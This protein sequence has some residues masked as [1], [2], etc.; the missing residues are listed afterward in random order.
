VELLYQVR[1]Y[2]FAV[3]A[4]CAAILARAW[5]EPSLGPEQPYITF[6]AAVIA[7]AWYAGT[8]PGL[9]AI[10]LGGLAADY[11]FIAPLYTLG[12]ANRLELFEA[13]TFASVCVFGVVVIEAQR[14][15]QRR[16]ERALK[17]LRQE[18]AERERSEQNRR[19]LAS[20]VESSDDAIVS[21]DLDG[22]MIAWNEGATRMY[23]YTKAEVVGKPIAMLFPSGE[24]SRP[25]IIVERMQRG[26][27]IEHYEAERRRKDGRMISVSVTVSPVRAADG[28]LIGI[29][30][31][32]RDITPRKLAE[33]ELAH[34]TERIRNVLDSVGDGFL[35]VDA[36]GRITYANAE[37]LRMA[38]ARAE[39]FAGAL[40]WNV[41]MVAGGTEDGFRR[42]MAERRTLRYE[43][44]SE[45][46]G[47]WTAVSVFPLQGGLS[48]FI[49]DIT[50][51]KK[52]EEQLRATLQ[53]LDFHVAN[54]PLAVVEWDR[55][56][57]VVRWSDEAA[58]VF[59]RSAAEVLGRRIDELNMIHPDDIA[60]VGALTAD[61]L[62]GRKPRNV[63]INRN[64]R[65]DGSTIYCE[66]YNSVLQDRAGALESVLSLVLDVTDRVHAEQ[67]LRDSEERLELAQRVGGIG[68]YDW[69]VRTGA[70]LW[71]EQTEVLFGLKRGGFEGHFE[72]WAQRV[73]PDD[74]GRVMSAVRDAMGR[75]E[76]Q[77]SVEYRAL[78]PDGGVHWHSSRGRFFYD[79]SGEPV[80]LL[81]IVLDITET[82]RT[83]EKLRHSAKLESLGILAGGIAH[84]FNNLLVGILGY[85]SLLA[86]EAPPGSQQDE[87]ARNIVEASERAS[88]L[89]R[90]ML[91]YS[92]KGRFIIEPVDLSGQVRDITVLLKSSIPKCV[93]LDLD[94]AEGLPAVEADVGQL[95]QL[96]MNLVINGAEAIS[97]EG[98]T[99]TV[100]TAFEPVTA[101]ILENAVV[102]DEKMR[103]GK[104]LT[105]EVRDSGHGMDEAT[106]SK[107][108]DPFFTTKFTGRGL[109]LAA[110]LGIVRGHGGAIQVSSV[111]GHGTTFRV[112]FPPAA[113]VQPPPE[114]FALQD[115]LRG[116]GTVLVIDD[117]EVVRNTAK[118]ALERYGYEVVL[119][120]DGREGAE[121]FER[122]ADTISVVL[123]D[124]TM[125]TL[126]GEETLV[127][128]R[129]V[130]PGVRVIAS[131]GF[132]H[133][134]ARAR[135]GA[136]V[137]DFLQKPYTPAQL[138]EKIKTVAA[139][140]A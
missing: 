114:K 71:T 115:G 47:V 17:R 49:R 106:R 89:T 61:M 53:R 5:L 80:R 117:E 69:D 23:G 86:E 19:L 14:R 108:F 77:V 120:R 137:A 38:G 121:V 135:F 78:W 22:I 110:V 101:D 33:Q 127:R 128:I 52:T 7:T 15:A 65:K 94:L 18:A 44:F 90:Q 129:A 32:A 126:S 56:F 37:A 27:R 85:A 41:P 88:Q 136:G 20:I 140:R 40:V 35:S 134:E 84:D 12:I 46:S 113:G 2:A 55:D 83:E 131:S 92:G 8:G 102:A 103:P 31:V 42:A 75:R 118:S 62:A 60:K 87:F 123:L 100:R 96:V 34:A 58:R 57:H 119:A 3:A 9:L 122:M 105:L 82:R 16:A 124:M 67:R 26:E 64:F 73:H 133:S 1:G 29:S 116:S 74:L 109:G 66:W 10:L 99:V 112:V 76:P 107:I 70:V 51:R 91:A 39:D 21:T 48:I 25:L 36:E 95:Q 111:P 98:G 130:R 125:P 6:I 104:Y 139:A 24:Q 13:L 59:G 54:S 93:S 138:A 30:G 68:V 11:F 28:T 79:E 97:P 81:G 72:A 45:P 43:Q 50:A 4:I 63:N 132:S